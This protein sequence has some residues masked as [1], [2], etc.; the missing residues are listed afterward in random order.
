[1]SEKSRKRY[2]K[3]IAIRRAV[4][5][6]IAQIETKEITKI[7]SKADAIIDEIEKLFRIN[8]KTKGE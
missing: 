7:Y 5:E 1:M 3:R 6:G 8:W 4:L 2:E